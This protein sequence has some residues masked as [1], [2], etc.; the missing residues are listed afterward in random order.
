MCLERRQT[1]EEDGNG[2]TCERNRSMHSFHSPPRPKAARPIKTRFFS[3]ARSPSVRCH[4]KICADCV[5]GAHR[6]RHLITFIVPLS[7]H[8]RCRDD[9]IDSTM[10]RD[11]I[12]ARMG[13]KTSN[14]LGRETR[15]EIN[16]RVRQEA[17]RK[18]RT[19][20]G[21]S[22]MEIQYASPPFTCNFL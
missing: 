18:S 10:Q 1:I 20:A 12:A 22:F 17:A 2:Q 6:N 19:S 11:F 4:I 8:K 13:M 15:E 16:R 9:K 14:Q 21:A 7:T 5:S 3:A